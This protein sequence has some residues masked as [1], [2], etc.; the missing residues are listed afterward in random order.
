MSR[1]STVSDVA[2]FDEITLER[3]RFG[4]SQAAHRNIFLQSPRVAAEVAEHL[5]GRVVYLLTA[6]IL[7][8]QVRREVEATRTVPVTWRDGLKLDLAARLSAGRLGRLECVRRLVAAI[9][10]SAHTEAI[11]TQ[12]RVY[13]IC[14]HIDVKFRD[15]P[16][17]HLDWIKG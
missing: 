1:E 6:D 2:R 15:E 13:H 10:R 8:R 7:G 17:I 9:H 5:G 16:S 3:I 4:V 12:V 11:E 14:P